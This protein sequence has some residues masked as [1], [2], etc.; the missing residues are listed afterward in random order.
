MKRVLVLGAQVPFV[1]GGAEALNESLVR[2]IN[3]L[4][5]YQAELV[6]VPY[7]W[8]PEEQLLD[9]ITAWRMLDLSES[10]G[11][12][13]DLVIAT[14][15]P[16]YAIKHSNKVLWLVHQHRYF[17]D[18]EYTKYDSMHHLQNSKQLRDEIRA[19]DTKIINECKC[20]YTIAK[21]VT[22]R[23]KHYNGINSEYLYPPAPLGARIKNGY[24]GDYIVYLGRVEDIKRVDLL[25]H[26]LYHSNKDIK[27]IIVGKGDDTQKV[28][29]LINDLGLAKRCKMLGYVDDE[30]LLETLANAKALFYAP[31]DEDYGYAT[32]EAFLAKKLVITCK[33]SG[34]VANI[35]KQTRSGFVCDV[36]PKEIAKIFNEIYTY[37]D[38]ELESKAKNGYEFASKINWK[39]VLDKLVIENIN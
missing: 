39:N 9:D 10:N 30:V 25:V 21:N 7:K 19:I 3:N 27:V 11:K 6:Q 15:F 14:K 4:D 28:Q 26:A 18:L 35:V 16:T 37:S 31:L 29:K 38:I 33:D 20:V 5:G 23:L 24:Y 8:Y 32:I 13:I 17:Y 34:E 1:R 12:K 36:N 22:N 2:E